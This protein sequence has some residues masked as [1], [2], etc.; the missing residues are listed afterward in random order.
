MKNGS[1][2]MKMNTKKGFKNSDRNK[3]A[4][5][6]RIVFMHQFEI[7]NKTNSTSRF[8]KHSNKIRRNLSGLH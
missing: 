3:S 4:Q 8:V 2:H 5:H 1:G 7:S 6:S